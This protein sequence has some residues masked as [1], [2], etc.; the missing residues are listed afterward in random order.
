MP[1]AGFESAIPAIK[2]LQTHVFDRAATG[3]GQTF[4]VYI[5]HYYPIRK[6]LWT[7]YT[8]YLILVVLVYFKN[9]F[10]TM[11]SSRKHFRRACGCVL[12]FVVTTTTFMFCSQYV[13][14]LSCAR[15]HGNIN[16]RILTE[17]ADGAEWKFPLVHKRRCQYCLSVPGAGLRDNGPYC[18]KA[19]SHNGVVL[20]FFPSV[21]LFMPRPGSAQ[22]Q[23]LATRWCATYDELAIKYGEV[24]F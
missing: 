14:S 7:G 8:L 24:G 23:E 4:Y 20:S 11:Y 9:S 19:K 1:S 16:M 2:R 15:H 3:I 21:G 6:V 22:L 12:I 13:L 10:Y 18:I 5:I 17:K